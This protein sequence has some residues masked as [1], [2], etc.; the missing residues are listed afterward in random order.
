MKKIIKI[1]DKFFAIIFFLFITLA[2][3]LQM[4]KP[5][6]IMVSIN[7]FIFSYLIFKFVIFEKGTTRE[8]AKSIFQQVIYII[9]RLFCFEQLGWWVIAVISEPN[10]YKEEFVYLSI[11]L[12]LEVY[13]FGKYILLNKTKT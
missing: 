2:A 3:M 6:W 5:A 7:W 9:D 13:L 11:V 12:L 1:I 8:D 4:D 10:I